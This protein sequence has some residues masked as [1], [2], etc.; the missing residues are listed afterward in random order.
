MERSS[1]RNNSDSD[2]AFLDMSDSETPRKRS[3]RGSGSDEM[4]RVIG[5]LE[6]AEN[7]VRK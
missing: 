6:E 7:F 4:G 5:A 3:R 1:K 2:S